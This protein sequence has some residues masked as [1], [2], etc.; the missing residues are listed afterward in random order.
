MTNRREDVH[1]RVPLLADIPLIGDLFRYD[2]VAE[3]RTELLIIM[4]PQIIYNKLDS[5]LVKQIE[6]SRMSWILSDVVNLHGEAGPAEPLRRMVRRRDRS[7]V[8]D[9]RAGR[10]RS[11][12]S[13]GAGTAADAAASTAAGT[14]IVRR[15]DPG[16]GTRSIAATQYELTQSASRRQRQW[17]HC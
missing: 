3:Q 6:S 13:G 4:T 5:D 14:A 8:S 16:A 12:D 15:P 7:G 2:S 1:R 11:G 17:T 9:L 10:R